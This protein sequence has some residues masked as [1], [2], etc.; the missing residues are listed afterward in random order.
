M[1]K[2]TIGD[3]EF[4]TDDFNEDQMKAYNE[5]MFA[6]EQMERMEYTATVLRDR[7]NLLGSAIAQIAEVENDEAQTS[8]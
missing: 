6:K 7:C 3:K 5:I 1:P 8:E 2:L 4:Y